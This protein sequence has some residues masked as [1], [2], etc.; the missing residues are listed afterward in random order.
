M[1]TARANPTRFTKPSKKEFKK[2]DFSLNEDLEENKV[3]NE[4][5]PL[6]SKKKKQL[7]LEDDWWYLAEPQTFETDNPIISDS[8]SRI[9]TTNIEFAEIDSRKSSLVE[10][11]RHF[12]SLTI[13]RQLVMAK[14]QRYLFE[15][16]KMKKEVRIKK[17][18]SK[19]WKFN[20]IM[21]GILNFILCLCLVPPYM[22]SALILSLFMGFARI[23]RVRDHRRGVGFKILMVSI[24]LII[25]P[26]T[27]AFCS[28]IFFLKTM[29]ELPF[30][31]FKRTYQRGCWGGFKSMF[32]LQTEQNSTIYD[33]LEAYA[34]IMLCPA[35]C[36]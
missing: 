20:Y 32:H 19:C 36:V 28:C 14:E 30:V 27:F 21:S 4:K 29:I 16:Q 10:S 11:F 31:T 33:L 7:M 34:A 17:E 9:Q 23:E 18:N 15:Q 8:F 1:K 35:S 24:S 25:F 26:V 22:V 3:Y 12:L 2:V 5:I 6:N 13:S